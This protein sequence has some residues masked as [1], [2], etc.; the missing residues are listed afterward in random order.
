MKKIFTPIL[1]ISLVIGI[2]VRSYEFKERFM[3]AHDND[4][5]SWIVKDIVIDSHI[6]LIGQLTSS[7]GIFIG[8]YY[9]YT[10]IPFYLISNWDPLGTVWFSVLVGAISIISV[11]YVFLKLYGKTPA[12]IAGFIYSIS[13]GIS[14]S[15]REVVP[16][17][18]VFLWCIWFFYSIHLLFRGEKKGLLYAMVLMALVWHLNLALGLLFPLIIIAIWLHRK[19]YLFKDFYKPILTALLLSVPL[20]LFE[21]RHG[22]SQTRSLFGT[23]F[24]MHTGSADFLGKISHVVL[25]AA[26]NASWI[27]FWDPPF[28]DYIIPGVL[29]VAFVIMLFFK[30]YYEKYSLMLYSFWLLVYILFFTFN[31]INLSEYYLNGLYIIWLT[32]TVLLLS[33]LASVHKMLKVMVLFILTLF[34][35]QNFTSFITSPNNN[36]GYVE[37][38]ALVKYIKIDSV[39][40]NYPCVSVSYMTTPGNNFGYRFLFYREKLHVNQPKSESPVYTIVFPHTLANRIDKSFGSLGLIL[41]DYERYT[42]NQVA[43]SCSGAN[44]NLTDPMFGF[45]K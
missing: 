17:T 34:T 42:P 8:P 3:Y 23:L 31:S 29:L 39:A 4:L 21:I 28:S 6:R 35:L 24:G 12:A 2:F 45:T 25:Y 30:K 26:R 44:A 27:L 16:T 11:Y 22:F 40:H 33:Y 1:L 10:L 18:P 19:Q 20:M 36:S 15:E 5:A 7:P 9:Y 41:P 13:F 14:G 37:R 32:F 38:T 43:L